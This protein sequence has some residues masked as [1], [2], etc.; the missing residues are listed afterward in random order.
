MSHA[1]EIR[2]DGWTLE[3][4]SGDLVREGR[5]VRL[6][7]Q[8]QRVLEALL[9]HPG[10]VVTREQLIAK[11]WPRGVV[12]FETGLNSAI[13]RLRRALDDDAESP[14]YIETLPRRG[15]RFIG[16]AIAARGFI[17]NATVARE[18]E[19]PSRTAFAPREFASGA[20]AKYRRVALAATGA[21]FALA[22]S[23]SA[24][25][26]TRRTP[27]PARHAAE[28]ATRHIA[29]DERY[30]LGRYFL[31]R[32]NEGD[33]DRARKHFEAAVAIDSGFAPAYAGLASAD[34]LLAVEGI[35]PE[36]VALPH[37]RAA[38]D[39]ALALDPDLA[40]AHMR[41]A[42]DALKSGQRELYEAHA[43]RAR[44][45]EPDN[46]LL[47]SDAS[48]DALS[49]GRFEESIALA[50]RAVAIEP[51]A[52]AYRY[53]L[54]SAL[55]LAGRYGEAKQVNLDLVE[56]DPSAWT[57]IAGQVLVLEGQFEKALALVRASPDGVAKFQIESLAYEGLHR[58]AE[59]DAALA[60][61]IDVARDRDP[62]RIVEVYAYRGD[63]DAALSWLATGTDWFRHNN[64]LLASPGL[65]PWALRMSPFVASLRD[66]PQWSE[67]FA[68][69]GDI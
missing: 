42:M 16:N 26:A 18:D 52:L 47:L 48:S 43:T 55:F 56:L 63:T 64:R 17:A 9:E 24:T 30:R 44:L 54:A 53:N 65:M 3:C 40:E 4:D 67:L 41:L 69:L 59:A 10:E 27:L 60:G 33:L 8:S 34:W 14:R 36:D 7:K 50:R 25:I 62:L 38:A 68:K 37:M 31:A 49:Q 6:R 19:A 2:F 12:D 57:D 61:L 20:L 11:L 45:A 1:K 29:A 5:T 15:Y 22:L 46:A 13:G 35:V 51:L 32:R 66:S 23:G 39:R 28:A 58:R 21:V